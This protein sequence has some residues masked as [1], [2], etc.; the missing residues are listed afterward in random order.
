MT[1]C[2]L[3]QTKE[4]IEP[5][6][7]LSRFVDVN[8]VTYNA[9]NQL[10]TLSG[11]TQESRQYNSLGQ[12][13]PLSSSAGAGMN[14]SY[15]FPTGTNNGKI[16]SAYNA[17][18]GETITYQYDSLNRLASAAGNGWGDTYGFDGFGNLLTKTPTAGPAPTLSQAVNPANNQ[19]VGQ[20]YDANG[21]QTTS[22]NGLGQL[23]YDAENRLIENYATA[24]Y[25]Y[26]S[27]NKRVWAGTLS[28]NTLTG[29]SASLYGID[30]QK[31]GTYSLSVTSTQFTV[32]ASSLSVY[33]AGK[34]VA[35][36]A[37][38]VNNP[39]VQD[40]LGSNMSGAAVPVSLYPWGEDRG[41]PAPN[42]QIK[43]ATYTR[44]S[45]TLLDYADQRYYSNQFGRFA[46]PD[47]YMSNTGG[48]GDPSDSGSW[49]RYAYTRGDPVNRYD[50]RGTQDLP[51]FGVNFGPLPPLPGQSE[52]GDQNYGGS[53][54][55]GG[56]GGPEKPFNDPVGQL[57]KIPMTTG[58]KFNVRALNLKPLLTPECVKALG[59]QTADQVLAAFQNA[60][61]NFSSLGSV[62]ILA[63]GGYDMT[64]G[65]T[66]Q[67]SNVVTLNSNINW[68][69][70]NLTIGY[71]QNTQGNQVI[72]VLTIVQNEFGLNS[73][74]IVQF[75]EM[76]VLHELGH[77]LGG[78]APDGPGSTVTSVQNTETIVKNCFPS[79]LN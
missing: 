7:I 75:V 68:L 16:S 1:P 79:L 54:G 6:L 5:Q 61:F 65:Q 29:Q 57:K 28:S 11:L 39:F 32:T 14:Y 38:G 74:S 13:I 4:A 49:N 45:S 58:S 8:G 26:D 76:V 51:P 53:P 64:A 10:P 21:N 46:T 62:V 17:V 3:G 33:F 73:L 55:V 19:I 59:A 30:G 35:I 67:G 48:T 69:A 40:R 31:L 52:L 44:D 15:N 24:Q 9:A 41:T 36:V 50:P 71:N 56:S 12:L 27:Q 20:T 60:T 18:T 66:F 37:G 34:R 22:P 72:P 42:D 70:P 78:L 47:P 63:G 25:A 43:F 2:G 23:G 77:I